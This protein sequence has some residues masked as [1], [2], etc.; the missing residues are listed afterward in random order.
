MIKLSI[1]S[2]TNS[3]PYLYGLQRNA[4]DLNIEISLD[5]P[6]TCAGKM[7]SSEA[8][9]GLVP[10]VTIQDI[11]N[12]RIIGNYG[13]AS[14]GRVTSVLLLSEVPMNE[15]ES[16]YL[17]YQSRTSAALIKILASEHWKIEPTW[18][19]AEKNYEHRIR[20]RNAGLVIGDRA[21]EL[22][23]R[24]KYVYDLSEAWLE[25]TGLPFVFACW[26]SNTDLN[27]EF[28][29]KFN[30]TL[31]SGVE[32][33]DAVIKFFELPGDSHLKEHTE[34]LTEKDHLQIKP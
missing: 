20:G 3:K 11:P 10:V 28:I 19:R 1:V 15:I 23:G 29:E 17:D 14:R 30:S 27:K 24:F 2:Y 25:M 21:L 8:N 32:N 26:V 33:I 16:I 9:V 18:V 6:A 13:I 7:I 22:K 5:D 4:A 31:A 34:Y 12:A